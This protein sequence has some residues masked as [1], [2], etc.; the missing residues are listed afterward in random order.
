MIDHKIN[1]KLIC[2]VKLEFQGF[3]SL[4]NKVSV[5]YVVDIKSLKMTVCYLDGLG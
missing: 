1:T 2:D 4:N 5:V 3:I